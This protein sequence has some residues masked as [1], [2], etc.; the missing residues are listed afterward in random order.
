MRIVIT[1][2]GTEEPLDG[3]RYITNFSTG[4]TGA[5]LA[6][7]CCRERAEVNLLHGYRAVTPDPH[8]R[9]RCLRYR[10]F[11]DLDFLLRKVLKE[12]EPV[13]AVIHLAAV[14]DFSPVSIELPDGR[15]IP[16]GSEGKLP[17][18]QSSLK[19]RMVRNEKIIRKIRSYAAPRRIL[20]VG[21]K[22]TNSALETERSSAVQQ[23]LEDAD[24]DYL[25]HNDLS[26]I[27]GTSHRTVMYSGAGRII[28]R[29]ETKA[30]LY[31]TLYRELATK[32][33]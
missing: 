16:A 31:K 1:S 8:P 18:D 15:E 10:S 24:L 17:S 3:V 23:L 4:A 7:Y 32:Q 12:D 27:T 5:G 21:F 30:A 11:Q 13:D 19:V 14:S 20:L 26:E 6:A 25:I 28:S 33:E 29:S 22:L 9:L 2:G